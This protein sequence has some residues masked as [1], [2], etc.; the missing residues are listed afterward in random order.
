[1]VWILCQSE[2]T[3]DTLESLPVRACED[4]ASGHAFVSD[5]LSGSGLITV[6]EQKN[7]NKLSEIEFSSLER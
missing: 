3:V 2:L 1:M 5:F 6:I 7:I 4:Q